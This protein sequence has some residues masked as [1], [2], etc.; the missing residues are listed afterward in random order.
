MSIYLS[1]CLSF[2]MSACQYVYVRINPIIFLLKKPPFNDS[3]A[4][5]FID[6]AIVYISL[7][8]PFCLTLFNIFHSKLNVVNVTF[9]RFRIKTN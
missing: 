2:C 5:D 9:D 1:I 7:T 8:V 3:R 6:L 4:I